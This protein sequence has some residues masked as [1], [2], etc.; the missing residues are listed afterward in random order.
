MAGDILLAAAAFATGSVLTMFAFL[1][2][3]SSQQAPASGGAGHPSRHPELPASLEEAITSFGEE[4]RDLDVGPRNATAEILADYRSALDAYERAASGPDGPSVQ[5]ALRAGRTALIRLDARSA[6]RPVPMDALPPPER[7]RRGR[8]VPETATGERFLTTGTGAGVAD[9]LIDRP[10]PGR[11]AL[12]EMAAAGRGGLIVNA[13]VRTEEELS[14]EEIFSNW[15]SAY[16][17][18]RLLRPAPTHLQIET[19]SARQRWSARV[20]PLSAAES[21]KGETRGSG[22]DVLY[23]GGGPAVLTFQI[24]TRYS[25]AVD[26]ECACLNGFA[27]KC[28]DPR[29]AAD[30][31][32]IPD[33]L[34][35]AG[36]SRKALRLPRP[37]YVSVEAKGGGRVATPW[38]LTVRP[39]QE[40]PTPEARGKAWLQR[41]A[42]GVTSR[43]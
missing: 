3:R 15:E 35:G 34:F 43:L 5:A 10:E 36:D 9:V 30:A 18:R 40:R 19:T 27:C 16:H 28:R 32:R 41:L 11:P 21:L 42:A 17:G 14:S 39:I 4:L 38:F 20:Q 2:R 13:V 22:D 7:G 8:P 23:Y 25:W 37:G 24:E 33:Q 31:E 26:F 6:G 29:W 12:L 1:L